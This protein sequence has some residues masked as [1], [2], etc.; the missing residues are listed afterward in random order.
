MKKFDRAMQILVAGF[1]INLCMG[2]LY[3]WSV[4]KK[5][6]VVDLGWSNADAS[7]PYTV[8]I[9]TFALSLLVAGI[10]QD[11]MGPRRVLILG[12]VMVGLGMIISSFATTPMMLVL[13]FG[14][15]TGCGIGFGYA[16]LSP[17]AMK[18]FHP[19]KKG[20]VNGLIAA[21]F[22]LAA[23][24]LAPL[25]S[26]LI[27]EYGINTSFLV[28]GVAVLVIAVPLAFTINNPPAD[29]VPETPAGY[30][31]KSDKPVDINWRGMLKTPQF[32]SLWVM[33]AFASAAGLMI[34]GNITSIAATQ[35]NIT[36]AAYLV[37]I[38]AIFNSGGRVAAGIL[39]D[40]IGGVKTLMIAFVM[41]GI[42]MVMFATFDS[43]FTLIIGAAVAG[44]GYGTLLAVFP[45]IIADFYGLKNYGANYGVLYT[46][47]GVSGFIGPVVAAFAVDTTGTY[48]LAYTVCSV[49]IAVAVV[50][51]IITKKVDAAAL[52]KKLAT[53]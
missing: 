31:A 33:Y 19:S 25:T 10:L 20:L 35:A 53:A 21:G 41:Q 16:C 36:D 14:I 40:K 32:Y 18:W 37:V 52:E 11:R 49:M 2:I 46:A 13:T 26:A 38:L 48:T 23:V 51:S 5:A 27:A 17:S 28:L 47:W 1:C 7:L 45:S 50:L 9:I 22:G 8:A 34:I 6:L 43:E 12:T 30:K 15:M 29:Y 24:Y 42:N 44:V 3:A 39:S 4:F